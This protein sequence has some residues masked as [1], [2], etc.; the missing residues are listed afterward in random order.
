MTSV[1]NPYSQSVHPS[2]HPIHPTYPVHPPTQSIKSAK[3]SCNCHHLK[4]RAFWPA[5]MPAPA[6][7]NPKRTK[8]T[9]TL[10]YTETHLSAQKSVP[11]ATTLTLLYTESQL[12]AQKSEPDATT[13]ILLFTETH[14]SAQKSA[15]DATLS[16]LFSWLSCVTPACSVRRR[17]PA[18]VKQTSCSSL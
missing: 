3:Q 1:I 6:E 7:L 10:L 4:D 15:P 12:S 9:L 8:S 2:D 18:T 13:L 17:S 16:T 5:P 11:D 14:L